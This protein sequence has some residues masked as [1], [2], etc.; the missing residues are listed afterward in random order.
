MIPGRNDP[1]WCGSGQKYK[2]CHLER[3][4]QKPEP[5]GKLFHEHRQVFR[6][7]VCL[8][9]LASTDACSGEA[10]RAHTVSA[11]LLRRI[12][13]N[14]HVYK[15]DASP[16][17]LSKTGGRFAA[18]LV[19][20]NE[21]ST[22]YGFCSRHDA[23]VFAPLEREGFNGSEQQVFLL[24]YRA[25]VREYYLKTQTLESIPLY[26]QTDKGRD[27]KTQRA[28]QT[29]IGGLQKGTRYAV[30]DLTAEKKGYDQSLLSARFDGFRSCVV[31][32]ATVPDVM[33]SGLLAPLFDFSGK[34]L[35]K[36]GKGTRMESLAVSIIAARTGGAM[37]ISWPRI[38]DGVCRPFVESLLDLGL[39][40]IGNA[41][42]RLAF[43]SFDN[44]YFRPE[45]WEALNPTL[46]Q[47]LEGRMMSNLPLTGFRARGLVD[48]G[49][50][51]VEWNVTEIQQ[52]F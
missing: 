29:I 8:H 45:W 7:P 6:R 37:S 34:Q 31:S 27:I 23:D 47:H 43:D 13:R 22:F 35:Q 36:L 24:A 18:T 19:G 5:K 40:A 11:S 38:N 52:T 50:R 14:G 17:V 49:I 3:E 15:A 4:S 20:V 1:C 26:R 39:E 28:I 44:I 33:C 16:E 21:A 48:D 9:P 12:A 42:I 41:S 51:T 30:R 10:I 2:K 32:F 46:R 25:L